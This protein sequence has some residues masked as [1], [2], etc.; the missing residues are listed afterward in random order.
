MKGYSQPQSGSLLSMT[1]AGTASTAG[2]AAS[3]LTGTA[4]PSP[5]LQPS[6]LSAVR[7]LTRSIRD[8]VTRGV[9][10]QAA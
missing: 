10:F 2:H 9:A 1:Q 8:E 6:I 5:F 3:R 7:A 4:R